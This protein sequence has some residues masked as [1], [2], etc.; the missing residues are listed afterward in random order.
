MLSSGLE[1]GII[2]DAIYDIYVYG[3]I[4]KVVAK[5]ITHEE[6]NKALFLYLFWP[7]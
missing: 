1:A 5:Y 4:Q 6:T 2:L 3:N 7:Y